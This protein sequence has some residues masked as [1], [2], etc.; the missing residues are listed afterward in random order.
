MKSSLACRRALD[1]APPAIK[2]GARTCPQ[3][4]FEAVGAVRN[5]RTR[6][7]TRKKRTQ[8]QCTARCYRVGELLTTSLRDARLTFAGRHTRSQSPC[9]PAHPVPFAKTRV[10]KLTKHRGW[11]PH[12]HL[13][14]PANRTSKGIDLSSYRCLSVRIP[15][16]SSTTAFAR[17][18]HR[19]RR[20]RLSLS[21][22]PL[23]TPH[24]RGDP[25]SEPGSLHI[26]YEPSLTSL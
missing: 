5:T 13:P 7:G 23:F 16:G 6:D 2:P 20:G 9:T 21:S 11:P 1:P 10:R 12:M 3:S 26:R 15:T 14:T 19:L 18:E 4:G 24:P 25:P 22:H 8:Y 17:C